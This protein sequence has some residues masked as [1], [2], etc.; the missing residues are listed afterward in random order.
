MMTAILDDFHVIESIKKP[1]GPNASQAKHFATAVVDSIDA[2]ALPKMQL[3]SV[4]TLIKDQEVSIVGGIDEDLAA[5]VIVPAMQQYTNFHVEGSEGIE[6]QYSS[7]QMLEDA[8]L[9]NFWTVIISDIPLFLLILD[10]F[11]AN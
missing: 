10:I 9:V 8:R 1:T 3:P 7:T 6:P 4:D 2:E 11:N 5:E